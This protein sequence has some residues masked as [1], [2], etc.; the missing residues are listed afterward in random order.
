MG[1]GLPQPDAIAGIEA[2]TTD[3]NAIDEGAIGRLKIFHH[4]PTVFG[5]KGAV[6]A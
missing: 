1:R 4:H 3:L 2:L 5:T 6:T